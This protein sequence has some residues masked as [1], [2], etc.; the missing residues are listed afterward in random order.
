[1]ALALPFLF[2]ITVKDIWHKGVKFLLAMLAFAV[3]CS[4]VL[5]GAHYVSDVL[6]GVGTA[7]ISLPLVTVVNNRILRSITVERLNFAIKVWAVILLGLMVYLVV[8]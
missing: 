6:A 5:L 1:M 2:M 7:L 8:L 3:C 4:R